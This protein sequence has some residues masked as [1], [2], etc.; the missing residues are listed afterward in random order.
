M[1]VYLLI[2]GKTDELFMKFK[3]QYSSSFCCNVKTTNSYETRK[4]AYLTKGSKKA[5]KPVSPLIKAKTRETAAA[6][7]NILTSKSSNCF[8]TNFQKGV[9]AYREMWNT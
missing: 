4:K 3:Y 5:V 8:R 2:K 6:A 1:E 7:I 9:P